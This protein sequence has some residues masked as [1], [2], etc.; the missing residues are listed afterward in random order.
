MFRFI[1]WQSMLH[2]VATQLLHAFRLVKNAWMGLCRLTH[3]IGYHA[4]HGEGREDKS[5]SLHEK[6]YF[7]VKLLA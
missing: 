7:L 1:L 4:L 2:S 3:I 6:P 5:F